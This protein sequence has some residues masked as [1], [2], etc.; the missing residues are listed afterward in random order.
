[1][2]PE[3]PHYIAHRKRLRERFRRTN[4]SDRC[5]SQKGC[6]TP[7]KGASKSFWKHNW[8]FGCTT[9]GTGGAGWNRLYFF[10]PY[11]LGKGAL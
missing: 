11:L 7:C 6:K 9:K 10:N 3:K 1:M 4:G 5:Y 8:G 2:A